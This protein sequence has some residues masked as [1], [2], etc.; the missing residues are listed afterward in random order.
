MIVRYEK[1]VDML[2]TEVHFAW[3]A[4]VPS[5]RHRPVVTGSEWTF[6]WD[7]ESFLHWLPGQPVLGGERGWK[8]D[9]GE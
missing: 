7:P 1:M 8:V 5:H 3:R 4:L 6:S 9:C 2:D